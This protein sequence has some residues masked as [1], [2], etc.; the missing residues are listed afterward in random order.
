MGYALQ[1]LWYERSRFF[2]AILAVMFSAVLVA[3]QGGLLLGLFASASLSI[4]HTRADVWVGSNKVC[5]VDQGQ[6]IRERYLA[7]LLAQPEVEHAEVFEQGHGLWVK[8]DGASELC[9][10]VGSRLEADALGAVPQLTPQ[11]RARL[12]EPGTVVVDQSD[13][14]RLGITGVGATAEISERRVRVVGVVRGLKGLANAYVFCSIQTARALRHLKPGE[15]SYLL[16]RCRTRA[17]AARVVGRFR[18]DRYLSAFTRDDFSRQSRLYW[19][20][21]TK[22]G[23]ALGWTAILGLIVGAVITGQTLY[24]ATAASQREYATLHALGISRWRLVRAVAWQ[25][26]AVGVVGVLLALPSAYA[27][28][29]VADLLGANVLLPGWLLGSMAGVTLAVSLSS[30][31]AALRLLL[32]VEPALLLR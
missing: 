7:R 4:D 24:A 3:L 20:T 11:M 14:R 22:A 10:I 5:T 16:A 19:L 1:T 29:G 15:T 12:T 9:M 30:G 25:C 23:L 32:S 13:L 6:P 2:P 8:P 17:D 21:K 28:A 31:L 18:G 27:L 26:L